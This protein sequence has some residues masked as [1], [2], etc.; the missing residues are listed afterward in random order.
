[1]G[2]TEFLG[3]P[4]V[5]MEAKTQMFASTSK[6]KMYDINGKKVWVP[7]S[8]SELIAHSDQGDPL[9][10]NGNIKGTLIIQK[11]FFEKNIEPI[12]NS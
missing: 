2:K 10:G 12:L 7:V 9:Y 6:A 1:M 11:W 3:K 5:I 8:V 4:A